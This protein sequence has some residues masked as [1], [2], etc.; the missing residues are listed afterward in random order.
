MDILIPL[1]ATSNNGFLEL[2]IAL[3]SIAQCSDVGNIYII[4]QA[5]IP[6]LKNVIVV[7]IDDPFT[8]NK[9]KNLIRKVHLTL[10]QYPE[11][12]DFVLFTD[13]Y[14]ITKPVSLND[15]PDVYNSRTLANLR[16]V[17]NTKWQNR[18]KFT[19]S[20]MQLM[21]KDVSCNWDSHT[22]M[23]FNSEKIL[24]GLENIDYLS[25]GANFTLC[26]LLANLCDKT[27]ENGVLQ[28]TVKSTCESQHFRIEWDKLFV[29]YN[30]SAFL[31]GLKEVLLARFPDKSIYE[32][33]HA[34]YVGPVAVFL[35]NVSDTTQLVKCI[36]NS[37]NPVILLPWDHISSSAV[38]KLKEHI[39]QRYDLSSHNFLIIAKLLA[40]YSV[41]FDGSV[42]YDENYL[43]NCISED[44]TRATI[45]YEPGKH[46]GIVNNIL[47]SLDD[48]NKVQDE[49]LTQ[50]FEYLA[51]NVKPS[52]I[53]KD[54]PERL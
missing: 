4:T 50:V 28:D 12:K 1:A 10:Q 33:D 41:L 26:T 22:P 44:A 48:L 27:K 19:L 16:S 34:Y 23:R 49:E 35:T 54:E 40:S 6:W 45:I 38:S 13:D 46:K 30:D 53:I 2:K 43:F 17:N 52:I 31:H 37:Y 3:R 14:V 51:D 47:V 18:L 36:K 24:N 25:G 21:G 9:D 42:A 29:G 32:S 5:K 39:V 15:I 20:I 8:D 11:I 7:P